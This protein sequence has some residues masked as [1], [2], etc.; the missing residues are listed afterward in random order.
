MAVYRI[1]LMHDDGRL[2]PG[3][4]FRCKTD[5]EA[6]THLRPPR[7]DGV[8]AELWQG[9]RWIAVAGR[10]DRLA[11]AAGAALRIAGGGRRG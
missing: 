3:E 5:G 6:V 11:P 9:G 10:F 8:R 4:S 2:E 1:Y 7:Q